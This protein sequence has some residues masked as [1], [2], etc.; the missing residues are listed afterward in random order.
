MLHIG[1]MWLRWVLRDTIKLSMRK[2]IKYI[3]G[4]NEQRGYSWLII[5]S[6][7][8]SLSADESFELKHKKFFKETLGVDVDKKEKASFK[9]LHEHIDLY[10]K[11]K[12]FDP[13]DVK[14]YRDR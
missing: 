1:I 5:T 10:A 9:K 6:R 14:S 2:Q 12:T 8:S 7:M 11:E 4:V 13:K 3:L